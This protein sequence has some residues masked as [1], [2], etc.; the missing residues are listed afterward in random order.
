MYTLGKR[1]R[2]VM[3]GLKQAKSEINKEI[4]TWLNTLIYLYLNIFIFYFIFCIFLF[5]QV[6]SSIV[7]LLG[8]ILILC[9]ILAMSQNRFLQIF[10]N[11]TGNTT[12]SMSISTL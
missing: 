7:V 6:Q 10:K 5:W 11:V 9:I 4:H 2:F 8:A 12:V 3:Y 1:I